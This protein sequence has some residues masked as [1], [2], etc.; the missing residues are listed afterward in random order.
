MQEEILNTRERILKA[1][2]RII[3]TRGLA[4]ATTKEIA[5]AAGCAEGTLYNHFENKENLFLCVL[6]ERLPDFI[7]LMVEFPERAG[8]GTV[9]DNLSEL[10]STA[11]AFYRHS[12]PL[13][14]SI[15]SEPDLLI[16]HRQ[17]LR[18][19]NAG[20]HKANELLAAYLRAEQQGGR[21]RDSIDPEAA[22][23]LLLGA[24]FQQAY[25]TQ[26]L[27]A[28][29]TGETEERFVDKLLNVVMVGLSPG[30]ITR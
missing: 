8:R 13:G 9:R 10:A 30:G 17:L 1:A 18:D 15:L 29:P 11:L 28:E 14:S 5:R 21:V 16:R 4:R 23:Y 27:G 25:W 3:R 2:E 22:A 20:P 19:R 26:F 24:C 6:K 7:R 12:I